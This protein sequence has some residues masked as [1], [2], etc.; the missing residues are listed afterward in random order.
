MPKGPKRQKRPADVGSNAIKVA[1]M[2]RVED[3]DASPAKG[4][5]LDRRSA[6]RRH[7]NVRSP[8]V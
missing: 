6:Y 1:R 4:E 7:F 3:G 8:A 5:L 2:A